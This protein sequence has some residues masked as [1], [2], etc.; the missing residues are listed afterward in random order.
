MTR[1]QGLVIAVV[2]QFGIALGFSPAPCNAESRSGKSVAVELSKRDGAVDVK[3]GGELFTTLNFGPDLPKPYFYPVLGPSGKPITR[4]IPVE[5]G[6]DHPHQK[7]L[8]IA[9]DEV[10][11]VDFWA[12]K[13][14]IVNRS[15]ELVAPKGDPAVLRAKNEWQDA[16]GKAVVTETTTVRIGS[17]RLMAFEIVFAAGESPVT[18]GD[19]K[20][21]LFGVRVHPELR[22]DKGTGK[23]RNAEGLETDKNCWSKESPWVDYSGKVEGAAQGI[24][25]FDHP[26]NFRRSRWHVRAYGLFSVNP[27]GGKAYTGDPANNGTFKLDAGKSFTLRYAAYVH[28]GDAVQG[29][30][31]ATYK[32]YVE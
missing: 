18:F 21:G 29:K 14:K 8:W 32:K 26:G 1:H 12:E 9:I 27:F 13:G 2:A 19:T 30:V 24:A 3:I 6:E 7:S 23:I 15:V 25:I 31:A 17:N 5:T 4:K 16:N 22:E 10:N 11:E 28:E 20:E